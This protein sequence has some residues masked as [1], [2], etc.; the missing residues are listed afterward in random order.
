MPRG[1]S[2]RLLTPDSI[3][4]IEQ[5]ESVAR[6]LHHQKPRIYKP[7]AG[8]VDDSAGNELFVFW[9]PAFKSCLV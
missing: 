6:G 4:M 8:A 7:T 3:V 1:V 9:N 2:F 5:W